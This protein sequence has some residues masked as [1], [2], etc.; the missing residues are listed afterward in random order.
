[1]KSGYQKEKKN[2]DCKL[3]LACGESTGGTKP[4]GAPVKGHF[5]ATSSVAGNW[6]AAVRRQVSQ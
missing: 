2:I 4:V 6:F 5:A 1:M 3:A